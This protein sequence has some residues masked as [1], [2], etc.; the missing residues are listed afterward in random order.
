MGAR[1]FSGQGERIKKRS[2]ASVGWTWGSWKSCLYNL[3]NSCNGFQF[4]LNI[5]LYCFSYDLT[6]SLRWREKCR[7]LDRATNN[8]T[9]Q[10][11]NSLTEDDVVDYIN[12]CRAT[13]F[14]D[15]D[16]SE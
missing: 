12:E 13:I 5:T 2:D 10:Q 1:R 7:R 4:L 11:K 14:K 6:I 15:E 8:T 16:F 3:E 9:S